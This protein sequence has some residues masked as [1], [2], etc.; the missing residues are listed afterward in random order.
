M[1]LAYPV[2]L[3]RTKDLTIK[4][5]I[6]EVDRYIAANPQDARGRFFKVTILIGNQ[7]VED[8]LEEIAIATKIDDS[9]EAWC[10]AGNI[11]LMLGANNLAIGSY[12]LSIARNLNFDRAWINKSTALNNLGKSRDAV[13][14]LEFCLSKNP[15]SLEIAI[16]LANLLKAQGKVVEALAVVSVFLTR[17]A[18]EYEAWYIKGT[19]EFQLQKFQNAYESFLQTLNLNRQHYDSWIELA[20]LIKIIKG[21]NFKALVYLEHAITANPYSCV[22][23]YQASIIAFEMKAYEESI[24]RLEK[25]IEISPTNQNYHYNKA[26]ILALIGKIDKAIQSLDRAIELDNE[27]GNAY[28]NRGKLLHHLG[29]KNEGEAQMRYGVKLIEKR[30]LERNQSHNLNRSK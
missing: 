1:E 25:A 14:T 2:E 16:A 3:L 7:S 22:A 19:L 20:W 23:H 15:N 17:N 24:D 6:A 18:S 9:C 28:V 13:E 12:N 29:R 27:F 4:A 21:D 5:Q 26:I 8:A 30:E 11:Q 10:I